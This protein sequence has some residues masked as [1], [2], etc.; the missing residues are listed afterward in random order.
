[1]PN[2]SA[3]REIIDGLMQDAEAALTRG[4]VDKA[5]T[6]YGGI[7]A[8]DPQNAA[9]LRQLGAIEVNGGDPARA[10]DLFQAAREIGPFDPDLCHAIAT[11]L[12]LMGRPGLALSALDAALNMNP[13]HFLYGI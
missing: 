8:N 5:R 12:R 11:A 1:M 10:L 7:L 6:L 3:E 9:A 2:M 4:A 13:R